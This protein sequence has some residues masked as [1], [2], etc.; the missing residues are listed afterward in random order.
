[1]PFCLAV[2]LPATSAT[3]SAATATSMIVFLICLSFYVEP[4]A[5]SGPRVS[6]FACEEIIRASGSRY[7]CRVDN[8]SYAGWP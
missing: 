1:M 2:A 8:Y 5:A 6:V 3:M 7:I 4:R